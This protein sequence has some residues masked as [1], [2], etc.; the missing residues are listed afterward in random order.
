SF[1][2]TLS[3]STSSDIRYA[4]YPPCGGRGSPCSAED[5]AMRISRFTL[6][7]LLLSGSPA[8][9]PADDPPK[10]VKTPSADEIQRLVNQLGDEAFVKRAQAKKAL[11]AIGE[12]AV[13]ALKKAGESAGDE[14]I[15]TAARALVAA[16]EVKASGV[17]RIVTGH[18][19]RVNGVAVT[20]DGTR[21]LS[22]S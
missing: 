12:P 14:E 19:N 1:V 9:V 8:I 7:I 3:Y 13:D 2:R 18:G 20:A 16:I 4:S 10:A 21:A 22:A 17:V 11:E 5:P 15:R 6:A